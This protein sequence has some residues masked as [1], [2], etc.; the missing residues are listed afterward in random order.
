MQMR[1][2]RVATWCEEYL[3]DAPNATTDELLEAYNEKS[4]HGT[5]AHGL[6]NVLG[7]D[8]RFEKV[9]E[10]FIDRGSGKYKVTVWALKKGWI[11]GNKIVNMRRRNLKKK[12]GRKKRLK[13]KV[14]KLEDYSK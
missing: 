5:T 6:G 2:R 8:K 9:G 10:S 3:K 14:T 4:S 1:T 11:L 13:T 7:K 12:R